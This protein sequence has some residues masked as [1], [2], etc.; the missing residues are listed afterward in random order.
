MENYLDKLVKLAIVIGVLLAGG[1][2]F[3]HYVVFLPGI[4]RQKQE[5]IE[6]EKRDAAAK[7]ATRQFAY[8]AC[9][10]SA[11]RDYDANWANACASV[12]RDK[13]ISLRNCLADR[14]IMTN[15][16]MGEQYC[17][18]T[19][20]VIDTSPECTLPKGRADSINNFHKQ[21]QERCLNEAKTGL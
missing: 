14:A 12:A 17:K 18:S 4:E 5:Q 9:I 20:G 19:Y 1:G 3:Y 21:A 15:R 13:Q 6:A 8:D 2:V 16:F 11:R 10:V 7:Q